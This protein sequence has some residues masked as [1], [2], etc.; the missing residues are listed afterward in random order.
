MEKIEILK[1]SA[2]MLEEQTGIVMQF[3]DSGVNQKSADYRIIIEFPKKSKQLSYFVEVKRKLSNAAIGEAAIWEK[4]NKE[5]LALVAECI[6][7]SQIENLQ[8]LDIA[9]FDTAGNAYFNE[10]NFFVFISGKKLQKKREKPISIFSS[11]GIKL[12]FHLVLEPDLENNDYRTIQEKTG[13]PRSTVGRVLNDLDRAGFLIRRSDNERYLTRKSEL[14]K[15]W[16]ENYSEKLRT[17]LDSV[18]YRSTKF[19]GRWWDNVDIAE[20]DAVWG[21]ETGGAILT[22]HL[23]PQTATIYADSMLPKLQAKFGLV[24]D[25]KGEIEIL[26]KFWKFGEVDDVAPPL[27]VYADLLATADQRNLETAQIIYDEYLAHIAEENS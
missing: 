23:R 27:V 20:Y 26:R 17:K 12:L 18:R 22:K 3:Q 24:R 21:G 16:V 13:V 14:L 4:S 6:T 2:E 25:E 1:K 9:F 5:K 15:R 11:N 7:P 19:D 10:A 8:K